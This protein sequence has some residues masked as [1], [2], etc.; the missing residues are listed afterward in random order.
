MF[1]LYSGS[2]QWCSALCVRIVLQGGRDDSNSFFVKAKV[3]LYVSIC[4][5]NMSR[6]GRQIACYEIKPLFFCNEMFTFG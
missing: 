4:H 6:Q 2:P 1:T 5:L 3:C